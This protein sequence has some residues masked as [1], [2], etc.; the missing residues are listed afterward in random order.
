MARLF[1]AIVKSMPTRKGI[2]CMSI[3]CIIGAGECDDID[4]VPLTGD[5]IIAADGGLKT[6]EKFGIIPNLTVGDFDSLGYIPCA[7]AMRLPAEKDVTDT[8]AA[9]C[10]G[11]A[12]GYSK[13]V[14]YGGTGGR[15][16]HT[17][18]N[19]QTVAG[20]SREGIM[21]LIRDRDQVIRAITDSHLNFD[22]RLKGTVSVFAHSDTCLGV[23]LAG[24]KY[25]L[26]DYTLTSDFPLGVS[27]E[28]TGIPSSV[29][30]KSGTL[31]IVHPLY[32][33]WNKDF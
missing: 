27:N 16:D 28:F 24:L 5:M 11:R 3:C 10:E 23:T 26:T 33:G 31:V 17:L 1:Y 15:T 9:I 7:N 6:A 21:L 8:Y 29:S 12:L 30:V 25:P 4:F 13:F 18:A 22:S 19:I 2:L 14:L 20:L 32:D